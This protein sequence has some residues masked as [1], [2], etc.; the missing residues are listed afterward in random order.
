MCEFFRKSAAV[1]LAAGLMAMTLVG[2]YSSELPDSFF[3]GNGDTLFIGS[4]SCVS[5][6]PG[7]TSITAFAE[8]S[9]GTVS[10][11]MLF[12]SVPIKN[13]QTTTV[14]RPMLVPCG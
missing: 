5:A 8:A 12:G 9:K 7:K 2:I 10:T 4:S 6:K 3:V 11:L 1:F 14:Q 13:V